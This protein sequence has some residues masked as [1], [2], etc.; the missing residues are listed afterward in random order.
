M[1][2]YFSISP[3]TSMG[4]VKGKNGESTKPDSRKSIGAPRKIK[5]GII[6]KAER[7]NKKS[8]DA[9]QA[10]E[11][12]AIRGKID[13]LNASRFVE[14]K[15]SSM[16]RMRIVCSILSGKAVRIDEIR[17]SH[18]RPGLRD[19]EVSFLRLVDKISN[20][21][22]VKINETGTSLKFT[23]GVL[24]GGSDITHECPTSRAAGYF[25]EP[26]LIMGP[27]AK[28][29]M[30]L[31]L[32]NC[33]T[34]MDT[35]LSVDII[36]A[37][38]IPMLKHFGLGST[39]AAGNVTGAPSVTI[40]KRGAP[41]TGGGEVRFTC[42]IIKALEPITLTNPGK[43]K[44]VRGVAYTT[45][46]SP[47]F[48]QRMVYS[49]RG[50]FN[51]FIP[52]VHIYAD[53]YKGRDSGMSPGFSVSLAAQS[54]TGCVV[55]AQRTAMN[56]AAIAAIAEDG[57]LPTDDS[58]ASAFDEENE[59][60]QIQGYEG[61]DLTLT[62]PEDVG[63]VCAKALVEEIAEGG[64]VDS[65]HQSIFCMLMALGPEDVSKVRFGKLSEHCVQTLRLLRD[66]W[67]VQFKI[68]PDLT[69]GTVLMSCLGVGY[70]NLARKTA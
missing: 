23:P 64:C 7:D 29:P 58:A 36:R 38:S 16:F 15:G 49:A 37:V 2:L 54:T 43:I 42:P 18:E 41:P 19:Y 68:T 44:K 20:G 12:T 66:F 48:G 24:I 33:V 9:A 34:N 69:D 39:D 11:K 35:D 14:L 53:H 62:V 50:V 31:L 40:H 55:S 51:N 52:D 21:S 17:A 45:R 5:Q 60:S 30:N 26:L 47:G 1:I 63:R 6:H 67:R 32:T 59:N 65:A 13:S 56:G 46:C 28:K 4:K 70:I 27:F 22:R 3:Q 57:N 8:M 10:V 61:A 25:L